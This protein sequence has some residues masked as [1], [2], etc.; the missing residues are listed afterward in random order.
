MRWETDILV[1]GEKPNQHTKQTKE[2]KQLVQTN[3]ILYCWILIL[4]CCHNFHALYYI[5][6]LYII[7]YY[8]V[9]HSRRHIS[10]N[11]SISII[12]SLFVLFFPRIFVFHGFIFELTLNRVLCTDFIAANRTVSFYIIHTFQRYYFLPF[13]LIKTS[14]SS[15]RFISLS[16]MCMCVCVGVRAHV[17]KSSD[18]P[19]LTPLFS[20]LFLPLYTHFS[21]T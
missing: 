8:F 13:I 3:T 12:V 5:I 2:K 4:L 10:Y 1:C 7:L 20:S 17:L 6:F 21:F 19:R 16:A 15:L 11:V 9:S 18:H 14:S